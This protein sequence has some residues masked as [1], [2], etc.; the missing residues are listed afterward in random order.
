MQRKLTWAYELA[1][2]LPSGNLP[3]DAVTDN[4][5]TAVFTGL[6][7]FVYFSFFVLFLFVAYH[8]WRCF[9]LYS[10]VYT[11]IATWFGQPGYRSNISLSLIID[12]GRTVE[13]LQVPVANGLPPANQMDNLELNEVV[14]G[15]GSDCD[16]IDSFTSCE[17]DDYSSWPF[18]LAEMRSSFEPSVLMNLV[19][20]E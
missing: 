4:G 2:V 11:E 5:N 18:A 14:I 19:I 15:L 10:R 1:T 9:P 12:T 17:W 13:T 20:F 16:S 7:A 8:L 3:V 6:D